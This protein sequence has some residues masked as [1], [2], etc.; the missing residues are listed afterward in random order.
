[1]R[2]ETIYVADDGNQFYSKQYCEEY[3]FHRYIEQ[4][5]SMIKNLSDITGIEYDALTDLISNNT[6]QLEELITIYSKIEISP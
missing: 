5:N 6:D 2:K 3:E 4:A 1:M